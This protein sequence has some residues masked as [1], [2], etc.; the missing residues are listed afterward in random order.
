MPKESPAKIWTSNLEGWNSTPRPLCYRNLAFKEFCPLILSLCLGCKGLAFE[1]VAASKNRLQLRK[2]IFHALKNCFFCAALMK[3]REARLCKKKHFSRSNVYS[4]LL[5]WNSGK[6]GFAK[7]N[8]ALKK[9]FFHAALMKRRKARLCKNPFSGS[10]FFR[11]PLAK[12]ANSTSLPRLS[13]LQIA[14][15]HAMQN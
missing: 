7:K 5:F 8:Q 11:M 10:I 1:W 12:S 4:T 14:Q 13:S 3:L 9:C 15:M 2:I 6:P